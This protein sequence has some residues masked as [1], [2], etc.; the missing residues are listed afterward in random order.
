MNEILYVFIVNNKFLNLTLLLLGFALTAQAQQ[1]TT[2]AGG[3]ATGSGGTH[4][5]GGHIDS[6]VKISNNGIDGALINF[7]Y[8][9]NSNYGSRSYIPLNFLTVFPNLASGGIGGY[10]QSG[11][12]GGGGNANPTNG[13]N[14]EAGYC[15]ITY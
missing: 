10:G 5:V 3:N 9:T 2:A 14:G 8:P 13:T 11:N 12:C 6:C 15:I 7:S 4:G 1:A